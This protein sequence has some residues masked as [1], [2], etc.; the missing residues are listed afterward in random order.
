MPQVYFRNENQQI[1]TY[2][3]ELQDYVCNLFEFL[4]DC[5]FMTLQPP[6]FSYIVYLGCVS[7][8]N[9]KYLELIK[10]NKF[11]LL[12]FPLIFCITNWA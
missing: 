1:F 12:K 2:I 6:Q 4:L 8:D 11:T 7:Q 5:Y 10:Q 9:R 3:A